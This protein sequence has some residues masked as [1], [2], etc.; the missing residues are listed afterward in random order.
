MCEEDHVCEED[1][2][3]EEDHKCEN[4]TGLVGHTMLPHSAKQVRHILK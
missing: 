4:G 3:S 1:I 2:M